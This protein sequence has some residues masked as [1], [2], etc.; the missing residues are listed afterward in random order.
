MQPNWLPG[1]FNEQPGLRATTL[2]LTLPTSS[3]RQILLAQ[4]MEPVFS[5]NK[6]DLQA[7]LERLP[8]KSK[9]LIYVILFPAQKYGFTR[10]GCSDLRH[11]FLR[12]ERSMSISYHLE[13]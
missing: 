4:D 5:L 1:D 8:N 6:C 13:Q 9:D 3:R 10:K 7:E 2:Y 12:N 11:T